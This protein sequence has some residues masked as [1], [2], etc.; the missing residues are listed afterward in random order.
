MS[1]WA[2]VNSLWCTSA[3]HR[4]PTPTFLSKRVPYVLTPST[5][6]EAD[7]LSNGHCT[8]PHQIV[9]SHISES[10][11]FICFRA[12]QALQM[13][14]KHWSVLYHFPCTLQLSLQIPNINS[15]YHKK[16]VAF[17]WCSGCDN[18]LLL[19]FPQWPNGNQLI[20]ITNIHA[21]SS[22][23]ETHQSPCHW[24]RGYSTIIP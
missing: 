21:V 17:Y 1:A 6:P 18:I 5:A 10:P 7:A 2:W 14:Q 22:W 16:Y 9:W 4:T 13:W 24:P 3:C 8:L 23:Q 19:C 15:L 12:V 11:A 20:L